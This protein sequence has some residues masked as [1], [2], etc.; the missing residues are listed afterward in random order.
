MKRSVG[1]RERQK[2]KETL[3]EINAIVHL[4]HFSHAFFICEYGAKEM[5]SCSDDT[6]WNFSQ[7]YIRSGVISLKF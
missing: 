7:F 2:I 1:N 3:S 6:R 5:F 4:I